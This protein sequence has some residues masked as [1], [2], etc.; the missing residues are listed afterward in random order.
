V[1]I[2]NP[3]I[4]RYLPFTLLLSKMKLCNVCACKYG[5]S[6]KTK[7]TII[8]NKIKNV[9]PQEQTS[10]EMTD[11]PQIYFIV[12][13]NQNYSYYLDKTLSAMNRNI[14]IT[15]ANY[16]FENI[17]WNHKKTWCIIGHQ[18]SLLKNNPAYP[19]TT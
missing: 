14:C 4:P 3:K 12:T 17:I 1:K 16:R 2:F 18:A 13:K 7:T 5:P 10:K 11:T 9:K 6:S 15:R 8:S 19:R